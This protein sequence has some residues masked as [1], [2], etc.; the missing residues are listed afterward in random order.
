[1]NKGIPVLIG[2]TLLTACSLRAAELVRYGFDDSA[3]D[4]VP[5]ITALNISAGDLTAGPSVTQ[6]QMFAGSSLAVSGKSLFVNNAAIAQL[7]EAGSKTYGDYISVTLTVD[8]GYQAD[9]SS[10]E[11]Y[12][13]RRETL[14]A[15][16]PSGWSVYSSADGFAIQLGTGS[17]STVADTSATFTLQ[18][19]DLSS[20]QDLT[21]TTEFRIYLWA[22]DGIGTPSTREWR[23]D[24]LSLSGVVEAGTGNPAGKRV[25]VHIAIGQS[26]MAG[27]ANTGYVSDPRDADIEYNFRFNTAVGTVSSGGLFTTLSAVDGGYYGPEI[28]IGRTLADGGK[29]NV[30]ILKYAWGAT[31]LADRWNSRTPGDLWTGLL[32]FL[33][34]AF[35]IL[36][37]RGDSIDIEGIYWFQ[38][39]SDSNSTDGP[40]YEANFTNF[41]NDLYAHLEGLGLD[42]SRTAFVTAKIQNRHS[43]TIPVRDAQQSVMD[44]LALGVGGAIIE[45][46]DL[47]TF[48]GVHLTGADTIICGERLGGAYL[49]TLQNFRFPF[50]MGANASNPGNWDF[51]WSSLPSGKVYDLVSS[52]SLSSP[53]SAWP[54]WDDR[55]DL[56]SD[57]T[58]T[59][60]I[61]V[62]GGSDGRRFFAVL[63]KDTP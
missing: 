33:G 30:A 34:N 32:G 4:F 25:R 46:N 3:N 6:S 58:T 2:A 8:S 59:T 53:I 18:S 12:T 47:A 15:G 26:N 1:M 38:G 13:L 36:T 16:S 11:F 43:G 14:G 63:E 61:N 23:L 29:E 20:L 56:P 42:T 35:G 52:T 21:G 57:G 22:G 28:G 5:T 40:N 51:T 10:L 50:Q 24:E 44:A 54:V 17:I 45:T 37:A 41:V 31:S 49:T 48:D 55:A 9:L 39:E 27:R 60:L 19:V 7:T 62:P